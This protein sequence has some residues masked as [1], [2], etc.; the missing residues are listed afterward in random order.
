MCSICAAF[1]QFCPIGACFAE[2][3][4]AGGKLVVVDFMADWWVAFS[5]YVVLAAGRARGMAIQPALST[6]VWTVQS[7]S[8]ILRASGGEAH[9]RAVS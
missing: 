7:D 1:V 2:L 6:Q 3:S 9:R 4:K 8:A 5:R